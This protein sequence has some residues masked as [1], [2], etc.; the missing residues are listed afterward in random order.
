MVADEAAEWHS[1]NSQNSHVAVLNGG[2]IRRTGVT[3]ATQHFRAL[4]VRHSSALALPPPQSWPFVFCTM[5]LC[6]V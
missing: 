6:L 1:A 3:R 4:R 2:E 5:F